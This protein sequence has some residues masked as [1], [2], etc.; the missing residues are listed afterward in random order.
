MDDPQQ[1]RELDQIYGIPEG[2]TEG[3]VPWAIDNDSEA[4][5]AMRKIASLE[6][7]KAKRATEVERWLQ[8]QDEGDTKDQREI[9]FFVSHLSRYAD[10]LKADGVITERRKSYRLPSGVLSFR[11]KAVTFAR[12]AAEL[13]PW[14]KERGLIRTKEEIDW[15]T[16]K[17]RLVVECDEGPIATRYTVIDRETGE[18]VPGVMV[19][20]PAH[21]EFSVKPSSHKEHVS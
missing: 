13:L 21:D 18:L 2:V 7:A 15:D 8:W 11:A 9:D 14:A 12:N 17:G 6:A 3:K 10:Q 4:D 1:D 16:L 5:W 20:A 19:D